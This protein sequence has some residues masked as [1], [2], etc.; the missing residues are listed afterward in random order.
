VLFGAPWL[1]VAPGLAMLLSVVAFNLG[2]DRLEDL[3]GRTR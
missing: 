2:G 1:A 3:S